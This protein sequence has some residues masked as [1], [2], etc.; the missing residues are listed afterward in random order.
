MTKFYIRTTDN[1]RKWLAQNDVT[2]LDYR[3][4]CL[5]DNYLFLCKRGKAAI[6]EHY[7]NSNMS[8]YMVIFSPHGGDNAAINAWH[9]V[10]GGHDSF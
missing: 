2:C 8:D 5:L 6:I 7:V 4:G 3:E 10:T 9:D 1:L